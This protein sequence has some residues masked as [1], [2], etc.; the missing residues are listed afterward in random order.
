MRAW[1]ELDAGALRHNLSALRALLPHG[2][3]LM[4]VVKANAYGHGVGYIARRCAPPG[5]AAS[6]VPPPAEGVRL[7]EDGIRGTI[8]VLG[9]AGPESAPLLARHSLAQ[10]V[11][12][13]EHARALS[14]AG[15]PLSVHLKLDTGMHRLGLPW[16]D[17]AALAAACACPNLTVTGIYTHLAEASGRS[18]RSEAATRAQLRRF[19]QGAETLRA[20]GCG[21]AA[22]HVQ[23]SYGLLNYGELPA[24]AWARTGIALYGVLSRP[25]D[26]TRANPALQPVLSLRARVVQVR[27]LAAGERAGYDGA[28]SPSGPARVAAVSIGYADGLPR[29]LS[30][31]RGGVLI[32]GQYA[33]IAGLVCM[34]QLLVDVTGIGGV[35]PGDTAT[36]I[37]RD[38]AAARSAGQLAEACGTIT[39]ELFSRLGPRLERVVLPS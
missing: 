17:A 8:L 22:L 25:G 26:Q 30:N 39:N 14:A 37:G 38:G 10:T 20:A 18:G 4:A 7:R 29:A 1:I 3:A 12:S 27:E 23:S 28:F 34:D 32:H 13:L 15:L 2:G 5:V 35:S 6:P 9:W 11:V 36:L 31:G 16:D 19:A 21:S 33:P 24:C